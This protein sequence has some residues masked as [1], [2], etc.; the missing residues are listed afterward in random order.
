MKIEF[1]N[2]AVGDLRKISIQSRKEFGSR[3]TAALALRIQ[4]VVEQI[5]NSPESAP[6]VEQRPGIRV[7]PL[8]RYPFKI[9]Y[10]IVGDTI[11]ILH[12]R[13]TARQPWTEN[14]E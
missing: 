6:R 13:Y 5:G 8:V 4:G 3:V 10:R 11:R 7:V 14:G 1:T 9:F 12:I 2:R